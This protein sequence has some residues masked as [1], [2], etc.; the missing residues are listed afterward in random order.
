MA[1]LIV[2]GSHHIALGREIIPSFLPNSQTLIV[3]VSGFKSNFLSQF[4]SVQ[5]ARINVVLGALQDHDTVIN[6]IDA[7]FA[8]T[9]K[10]SEVAG[11]HRETARR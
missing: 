3:R 7:V 10:F 6:V 2:L 5:L 1:R 9:E 8:G 4:S 11:M